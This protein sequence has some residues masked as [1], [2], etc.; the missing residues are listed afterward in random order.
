MP[1]TVPVW[2]RILAWVL[3]VLSCILVPLSVAAVWTR[4]ELLD[5]DRYV[6]TVAPLA[7]NAEIQQA[8]A[9][10]LSTLLFEN[11]DVEELATDA[12][13]SQAAFLAGPLESALR[14]FV[15]DAILRVLESERF[16]TIWD[17][18][19]R[20]A[21]EQVERALTGGGPVISTEDG[22]VVLNLDGIVAR[23]RTA[24]ADRG[25]GI[26]DD[27]PIGTL[28]LRFTLFDADSLEKAQDAIELI[29]TLRIVLPILVIV[30]GVGAVLLAA[31]HRRMIFRW[32]VGI[33]IAAL[34]LGFAISFGRDLYLDALPESANRGANEA[35]FDIVV[36]FLRNS[37]RIVFLVG[38]IMAL[39]AWLAGPSKA[40]RFLRS[41]TT[42]ALE[43]VGDQ[44]GEG[45]A[46]AGVARFVARYVNVFRIGGAVL[47]FVILIWMDHPDATTVLWLLLALL[48]YLAV[49]VIVARMGRN[50]AADRRSKNPTPA[51]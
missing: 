32:G 31:D 20:R 48:V 50:A 51:A 23:V 8:V 41:R 27:L 3:L 1:S 25:I 37:N 15:D 34:V 38:L 6:Q 39:G 9:T 12:L 14:E 43:G 28:A 21:H 24:L 49:V 30:F 2:R 44:A 16:Q 35:A 29:D 10:R 7:R 36:R 11:V 17:E 47:A 42:G 13:P 18:A 46:F 40:A 26:F 45:G 4:S 19:N 22:R 33:V 5:T